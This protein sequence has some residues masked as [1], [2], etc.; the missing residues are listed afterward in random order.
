M[1]LPRPTPR[2]LLHTRQ[3]DLRGYLREDGLVDIEAHLTDKKPFSFANRDRDGILAGEPLHEMWVRMTVTGD[4][5][6]IA[7]EASMDATPYAI[8]P[9]I[10]PNMGR[11]VGLTIGKG[12]LRSAN[13]R[14]AGVEGCTHLRELLQ[15]LATTAFQ[16]L[17][18]LRLGESGTPD[19][20]PVTSEPH[21]G[22]KVINSC[23]AYN[24]EGPVIARLRADATYLPQTDTTGG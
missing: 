18:S 8:C 21:A 9:Q 20:A 14:M 15:P 10:A 23:H 6:I 17:V 24:E 7:C 4:L 19:Q 3:V 22:A 12:F 13:V 16:T 1:P 11:L 5:E 2:K